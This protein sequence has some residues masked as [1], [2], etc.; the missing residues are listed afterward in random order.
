MKSFISFVLVLMLLGSNM[1][2]AQRP[3]AVEYHS[4]SV[5]SD[6]KTLYGYS[7]LEGSMSGSFPPGAIRH[8]YTTGF[9]LVPPSGSGIAPATCTDSQSG[10]PSY[11]YDPTCNANISLIGLG[12]YEM[13]MAESALCSYAG[14]FFTNTSPVYVYSPYFINTL[15]SGLLSYGSTDPASG[16]MLNVELSPDA[17]NYLNSQGF[18]S[19]SAAATAVPELLDVP[20]VGQV[21]IAILVVYISI[22]AVEQLKIWVENRGN[23]DP[24]IVQTL[25]STR[26]GTKDSGGK[27]TSSNPPTNFKM[28][29]YR[30]DRTMGRADSLAL[31]QLES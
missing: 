23:H 22:Q 1:A 10:D 9:T 26:A 31:G 29:G 16:N 5:S 25:G 14:P 12:I 18:I 4:A 30:H 8:T 20:G 3:T 28:A 11:N 2:F 21:V 13:N 7:S 15:W 17:Y 19:A 6:G 27:C 24:S